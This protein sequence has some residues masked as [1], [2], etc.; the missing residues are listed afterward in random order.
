[1]H[2]ETMWMVGSILLLIIV[3]IINHT[4]SASWGSSCTTLGR[5]EGRGGRWE[6]Q[7]DYHHEMGG[8][9]SIRVDGVVAVVGSENHGPSIG[10]PLDGRSRAGRAGRRP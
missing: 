5:V 4:D 10:I 6:G 7:I 2:A 1:M 8:T 3:I 9:R